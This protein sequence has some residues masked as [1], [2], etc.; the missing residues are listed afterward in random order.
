VRACRNM[1]AMKPGISAFHSNLG[2][3]IVGIVI[4]LAS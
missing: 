4:A 3:E 2:K 1:R